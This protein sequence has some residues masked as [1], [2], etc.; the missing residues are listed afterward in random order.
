M[1]PELIHSMLDHKLDREIE[2]DI[3]CLE[4]ER[5]RRDNQEDD[6]PLNDSCFLI[7]YKHDELYD[8]GLH[9]IITGELGITIDRHGFAAKQ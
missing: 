9:E 4:A 8:D 5:A 6:V 7:G 1:N 2:H 3:R